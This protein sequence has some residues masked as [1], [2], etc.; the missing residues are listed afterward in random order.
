MSLYNASPFAPPAALLITGKA[1]YFF[2]KKSEG[3]PN[4]RI[5]IQSVSCA[6]NIAVV[7]GQILEGPVPVA[8]NLISIAGTTSA[9]GAYNVTNVAITNVQITVSTGIVVI[10]F[11]LTTANL[12][13]VLDAG[14]AI[15]PIA[16]IADALTNNTSSV[17]CS[18]QSPT[19]DA[20][21]NMTFSWQTSFPSQPAGITATLQGA[22]ADVD[23][24]YATLDTSTAVGGEIRNVSV[25]GINFLRV[26]I[27]GLG[28][29]AP[30]GIIKGSL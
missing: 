4:T 16:E 23:G 10:T 21:N 30:T 20:A 5:A 11:P 26:R 24:Q 7:V 28:G 17:Q 2:G 1:F 9:A 15:V 14:T 29:A 13:Q 3:Q 6:S 19:G 18:V 25:D 12:S 22:I 27:T 8:G